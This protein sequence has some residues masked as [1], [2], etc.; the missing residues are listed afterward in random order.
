MPLNRDDDARRLF[1]KKR[2]PGYIKLAL[3]ITIVLWLWSIG[4]VLHS[5]WS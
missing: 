1:V 4:R 2:L 3:I 5:L